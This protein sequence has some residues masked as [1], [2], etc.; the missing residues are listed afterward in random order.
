VLDLNMGLINGG[1]ALNQGSFRSTNLTIRGDLYSGNTRVNSSEASTPV[2]FY[3]NVNMPLPG[4]TQHIFESWNDTCDYAPAPIP[5]DVGLPQPVSIPPTISKAFSPTLIQPGGT[6]TLT[7]TITNNSAGTATGAWSFTDN[8]PSVDLKGNA[9]TPVY[10]KVAANPNWTASAGCNITSHSA[11]AGDNVITAAGNIVSGQSSCVVSVQVMAD[12]AAAF[13]YSL[14]HQDAAGYFSP[15]NPNIAFPVDFDNE[16][17]GD[18]A[19]NTGLTGTAS[20]TLRVEV[21]NLKIDVSPASLTGGSNG[22]P[23]IATWTITVLNASNIETDGEFTSEDLLTANSIQV[24]SNLG[25]GLSNPGWTVLTGAGATASSSTGTQTNGN[26]NGTWT[27]TQ[28]SPGQF[29]QAQISATVTGG[30]AALVTTA[31]DGAN[32]TLSSDLA[33]TN[34]VEISRTDN[35]YARPDVDKLVNEIP[36]DDGRTESAREWGTAHGLAM[37]ADTYRIA[38][39]EADSDWWDQDTATIPG[40]QVQLTVSPSVTIINTP[41]VI[42]LTYTVTNTGLTPLENLQ[43]TDPYVASWLVTPLSGDLVCD[44]S[45]LGTLAP[46]DSGTCTAEVNIDATELK[47]RAEVAVGTQPEGILWDEVAKQASLY[48]T[49]TVTASPVYQNPAT[50]TNPTGST[51]LAPTDLQ[52]QTAAQSIVPILLP[53]DLGYWAELPFTGADPHGRLQD[54][55]VLAGEVSLFAALAYAILR[56]RPPLAG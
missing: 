11:S 29:V 22:N 27:L 20:A 31:T 18:D 41:G 40:S 39:V 52:V 19:P 32:V 33:L 42:T 8:L 12:A 21:P 35:M 55:L 23:L 1:G 30:A 53:G 37:P 15:E 36:N 26:A 46:G 3:A 14:N 2:P 10:L 5:P 38:S 49:A 56:K 24:T 50:V 45:S 34:Q 47:N 51:W 9:N 4:Q 43:I 6:S 54:Y 44:L 48:L 25:A 7:F 28:L 16:L 13:S 17:V